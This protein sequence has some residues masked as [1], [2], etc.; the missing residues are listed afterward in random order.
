[1]PTERQESRPWPAPLAGRIA[2]DADADQVADAIVAV[3]L[4]ID[5]ALHPIIGHRGVA[6]LHNR[7]LKLTA[8]TYPWLAV[9]HQGALAAIDVT[10][11]RATLVPRAAAQAAAGGVALF[12]SF[13][14]LLA[15]LV[16]QALADQLLGSVW[17][18]PSGTSPAQDTSK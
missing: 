7:S 17:A 14:E 13:R 8:A 5:Q 11:L 4:E 10:A 1:M 18:H 9:G 3:W 2:D 6:A 16:G 15:S 12:Q